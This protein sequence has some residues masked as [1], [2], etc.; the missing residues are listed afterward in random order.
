MSGLRDPRRGGASRRD[1]LGPQVARGGKPTGVMPIDYSKWDHL[2]DFGAR[3]RGGQNKR[4]FPRQGHDV[5]AS[6]LQAFPPLLV[7]A[8]DVIGIAA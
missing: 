8:L 1:A 4:G 7:T 6:Y 3:R 2:E 5:P